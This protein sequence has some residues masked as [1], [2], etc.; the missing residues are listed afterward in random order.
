MSRCQI[1]LWE[2]AEPI[3]RSELL[4]R[5][6][7]VNAVFCVL[8]DKIDNEILEAAGPQLQVVAS[9]SVGIDHLDLNALKKRG[10]KIGYTP[11]ILTDATA[12]LIVALLLATSRRLLEANRAIYKYLHC[13]LINLPDAETLTNFEL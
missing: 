1:A 13:F 8:T 12:E 9:M 5:I 4:S 11:G 6:R 10:I 3:P 7:G 2:K